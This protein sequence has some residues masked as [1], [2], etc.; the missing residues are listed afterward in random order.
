MDDNEVKSYDEVIDDYLLENDPEQYELL[1]EL[2]DGI[3]SMDSDEY[4]DKKDM[5]CDE[6]RSVLDKHERE[7]CDDAIGDDS[8]M[9]GW[10]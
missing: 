1:H 9:D 5:L 3:G 2:L 6:A 4:E 8:W 7:F 10:E